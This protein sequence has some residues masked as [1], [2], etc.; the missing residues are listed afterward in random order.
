MA[1]IKVSEDAETRF[2]IF[3]EAVESRLAQGLLQKNGEPVGP[4]IT[5]AVIQV[6]ELATGKDLPMIVA[7]RDNKRTGKTELCPVALLLEG[8][9]DDIAKKYKPSDGEGHLF[10][11]DPKPDEAEGEKRPTLH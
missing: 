11:P 7:M 5:V 1:K 4:E 6:Q 10:E 3:V 2:Q 9:A 8:T